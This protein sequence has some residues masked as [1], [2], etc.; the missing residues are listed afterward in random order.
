MQI[1][2]QDIHYAIRLLGKSPGFTIVAV[3]TLALGIGANAAIFSQVNAI[4]FKTLPVERP[5]E[6][7]QL[8]FTSSRPG[9]AG[10]PNNLSPGPPVSTGDSYGTF[11]YGAYLAMR[12]GNTSFSELA[13]W[14]DVGE[15]RPVVMGDAG[16]ASVQFVSGNYFQALGVRPI[17]GRSIVPEDDELRSPKRVLLLSYPFW[18]RRFGGDRGVINQTL[19]LNRKSFAIIGVMPEG[20]FGLDPAI[21][22]DMMAPLTTIQ[23][24]SVTINPLEIPTVW[25]ACRAFGRL[26]A[27]V[28]EVQAA[29]DVEN[30]VHENI[31]SYEVPV[32]YDLPRL[33]VVDAGYGVGSLG[34]DT[35]MPLVVLMAVVGGILLIACANIAGLLLARSSARQKEIATR[36]SLGAPRGRLVRQL[37][38]ESVLLSVIGG[39]GGIGLAF[40]L[41][42]FAPSLIS[43]LM[44]TVYGVTRTLGVEVAPDLRV[45]GFSAAVAILTG[46]V[47]GLVPALRATRVDLASM[48]KQGASATPQWH[49]RSTSGKAM[50]T[51][52]TALA[53]LVLIGAGLFIRTVVN[54][55]SA[56]LG[57]EPEGLLYL[58]VEPNTGGVPPQGRADFFRSV[59]RHL[60]TAPGAI[61]VSAVARPL[62]GDQSVSVGIGQGMVRACTPDYN[63][64]GG[65]DLSVGLNF[66]APRYFETMRLPLLMGRD[67]EWSDR[68]EQG[69]PPPSVVVNEAFAK[70][71]YSGKSPLGQALGF[72]CPANPAQ[73]PVIG[74]VADSKWLPQREAAPE[75]YMAL[76]FVGDPLTLIVRTAGDPGAIVPSIRAAVDEM[77]TNVPVYGEITPLALRD[78]QIKQERLLATLLVFFANVA[79][80]LSCLGIYGMLAY[81]VNRR[82]SE[83]GLRMALGA[84]R[85]NVIRM[86]VRDSLVPVGAGIVL[87]LAAAL[88]STRLIASVLFG[89]SPN[90]PLTIAGAIGVFVAVA[91]IA[92]YVPSLRASRIDP[93]VAL[94]YD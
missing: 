32:E 78:Q 4:L 38:T 29:A 94:R 49:V 84:Q 57:Y 93:L 83:I 92:A 30:W 13:C 17:L 18:Q 42:R 66:V 75:V 76:G 41:A 48:L 40:A 67:L 23:I 45:L 24:I 52:Q 60:E 19:E 7:R 58:K 28:S 90:D 65:T 56:E 36:I 44:P 62:L 12:D 70:K 50:V 6:L 88:V 82:T 21:M 71:Y 39:A 11:S 34:A 26:R 86:V 22:P 80:L 85:G 68:P 69:R 31:R 79:L 55:R 59:V 16:F 73:F 8:A 35:A 72:N 5:E 37:L 63:P 54:L 14:Q 43:Q 15:R 3:L 89:V 77:Q 46:V 74:V 25:V 33:W 64:Q 91:L 61:S 10:G 81:A 51:V 53:M 2:F 87:G 47:F 27:G 20:F 9:F 1:L